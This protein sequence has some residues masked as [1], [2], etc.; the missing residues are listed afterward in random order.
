MYGNLQPIIALLVAWVALHE[1][2][3]L[4]QVA[5]GAIVMAGLLVSRTARMQPAGP[6]PHVTSPDPAQRAA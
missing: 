4:W 2:P 5:G 3:T 1:R 6:A